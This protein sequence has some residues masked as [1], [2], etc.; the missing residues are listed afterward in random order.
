MPGDAPLLDVVGDDGH[1]LEV[2]GRVDLVHHVERRRLHRRPRPHNTHKRTQ[3]ARVRGKLPTTITST[4]RFK[5]K[6]PY[7]P[8]HTQPSQPARTVG[9]MVAVA[10]LSASWGGGAGGS[11]FVVVEREDEGQG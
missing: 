9:W 3:P 6:P 4:T 1:V 8:I 11:H 10:V 7:Y 5:P 2:E